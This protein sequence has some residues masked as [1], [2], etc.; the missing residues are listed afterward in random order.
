MFKVVNKNAAKIVP[1]HLF[2]HPNIQ[3]NISLTVADGAN[4]DCIVEPS[5]FAVVWSVEFLQSI[6]NLLIVSAFT[7]GG[8]VGFEEF[9]V[10]GFDG[11]E[12]YGG[13]VVE[14][15]VPGLFAE[16]VFQVG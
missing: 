5:V 7:G 6:F 15:L 4:E 1:N 16:I 10:E 12:F 13:V 8:F 9:D 3:R 11:V 2:H 14:G